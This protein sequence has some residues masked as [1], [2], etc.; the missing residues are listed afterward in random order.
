MAVIAMRNAPV[1]G[2]LKGATHLGTIAEMN[3][4][5]YILSAGMFALGLDAY[6][7][8]GILPS[9]AG[10]FEITVSAAGLAVA[11]FTLFYAIS[12]PVFATVLAGKSAKAILSIALAIFAS[13]NLLSALSP[14]F[15]VFL[16]SRALAGAGAGLFSPSAA[17]A[18]TTLANKERHGR[19]LGFILGGMSL[20][21]VIGVPVG[22][23][24]ADK[25]GWVVLFYLIAAV[26]VVALIGIR[27]A[28][29]AFI[30]RPAPGLRERF[31]L[32]R[33]LNVLGVILVTFFLGLAS[34]GLYTYT[35]PLLAA[36]DQESRL[37]VFL[38]AWGCGG[39]IGSFSVGHV[40]DRVKSKELIIVWIAFALLVTLAA[41]P[42]FA[43]HGFASL[44][45][46]FL[47]GLLG[48]ASQAPQQHALLTMHSRHGPASV[49]LNSSAN[50]LGSA[51]GA[52]L[53]G[54][55]LS[56]TGAPI[57]LPYAAAIPTLF[58]LA[59]S[60]INARNARQRCLKHNG[61]GS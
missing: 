61:L 41:L 55:F 33:D 23:L 19:A 25:A 38:W 44:I 10:S 22:L 35:A 16:I 32:L 34:L 11:V 12:A 4:S 7:I 13:A 56:K 47:W 2:S 51:V 50:Y 29:P 14:H 43:P 49:A 52:A 3:R 26:A 6:V 46:F 21:T 30:P 24:I 15:D 27:V 39:I 37:P 8:A 59:L 53:G 17:A 40:I 58:A 36:V 31:N 9:I 48:W 20:G 1:K 5:I 54:W 42:T 28:F 60:L 45:I 57:F 18:A